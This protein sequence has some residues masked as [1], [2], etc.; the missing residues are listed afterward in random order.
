MFNPDAEA[1]AAAVPPPMDPEAMATG[2][3]ATA[4]YTITN[5]DASSGGGSSDGANSS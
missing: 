5:L 2:A 1:S 3:A 4:R